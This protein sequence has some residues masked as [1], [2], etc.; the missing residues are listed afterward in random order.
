MTGD[1]REA[2]EPVLRSTSTRIRAPS[3]AK[4][5]TK[6]TGNARS[7]ALGR[8][9]S[10]RVSS[11]RAPP[12]LSRDSTSSAPTIGEDLPRHP[13]EPTLQGMDLEGP[14]E[15]DAGRD[16]EDDQAGGGGG[17]RP[18]DRDRPGR[19]G[20]RRRRPERGDQPR[21]CSE[22]CGRPETDRDD[23]LDRCL[24]RRTGAGPSRGRGGT[25]PRC[26][27]RRRRTPRPRPP[28]RP[29]RRGPRS[30]AAG[31]AL[32][33]WPSF[34]RPHGAPAASTS[35]TPCPVVPKK[36]PSPATYPGRSTRRGDPTG[37][38]RSV[39]SPSIASGVRPDVARL[40]HV[41]R[42]VIDR[43]DPAVVDVPLLRIA[44]LA[45]QSDRFLGSDE[46]ELAAARGSP[47]T[48]GRSARSTA[49]SIRTS[50]TCRGRDRRRRP[51]AWAS[52]S[53]GSRH[54]ARPRRSPRPS[55]APRLRPTRRPSI[56]STCLSAS[57]PEKIR[58]VDRAGLGLSPARGG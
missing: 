16:A 51:G 34:D 26:V 27:A 40:V 9:I 8:R 52:R 33:R 54:P 57:V 23:C 44:E 56:T 25:P 15:G 21:R 1:P 6:S 43:C 28:R 11:I 10:R 24:R 55:P 14:D 22:P 2:R 30:G 50:A 53:A 19:W 29:P 48:D 41:E 36:K 38:V 46:D 58:P 42:Q 3:V 5:A 17:H 49:T 31:A 13:R 7:S 20:H 47:D 45:R 37:S 32:R 39:T 4:P 35:G 12:A 18:C